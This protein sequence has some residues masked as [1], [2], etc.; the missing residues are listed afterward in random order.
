MALRPVESNWY[1][2]FMFN[3]TNTKQRYDTAI[4][5]T[6]SGKRLNNLSD[7]PSDMSYVLNL[8][9]KIGQIDQFTKN[10]DSAKAYLSTAESALNQVENVI[11]SIVNLTEQ[12]ASETV[13]P[14]ERNTIADSIEQMRDE[15]LNYANTQV[16]GRYIFAGSATDTEPFSLPIAPD[17][18]TNTNANRPNEFLYY[19]NS[20]TM[21]IQA[22]FSVTVASNIPG[23]EIFGEFGAAE[24]PYDIFERIAGIVQHLREDDTTAIGQD[25]G[26]M[27]DIVNQVSEN[28]GVIGNRTSHMTEI[29]G[30]LTSFRSSMQANMSSLE[31]ANMAEA[32]SNLSREEIG[33]QATLQAGSRI[34][35]TS[36]MNFLG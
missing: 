4:S 33:L 21:E 34:Q 23:N 20:D 17:M 7:D 11:I 18:I 31:D 9:S 8:R 29:K 36:L 15:I 16:M 12:G 10:I 25:I 14:D 30:M 2:D 26:T 22:D 35:R 19:G 1:R 13:G 5:Q 24:P 32:I 27:D 28:I 6:S 3:L